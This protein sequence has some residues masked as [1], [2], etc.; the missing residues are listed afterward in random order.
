LR[1]YRTTQTRIISLT[2]SPDDLTTDL[3]RISGSFVIARNTAFIYKGKPVE[4]KQIGRELGVR[5]VIE[6]TVRRSANL[7]QV[8]AQLIDTETG[9]HMWADRFETDRRNLPQEQSE[10]TSRLA[11]TLNVQLIE[12]ANSRLERERSIDPDAR[13]LVMRGWAFFNRPFPQPPCK[14]LSGPSNEHWRSTHAQLMRGS[15][16]QGL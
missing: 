3:S 5:Y 7:I 10:I 8:N 6:G 14:R 1:T 4:V 9:G 2:G 16:S 12:A 13:D 11:K 15:V